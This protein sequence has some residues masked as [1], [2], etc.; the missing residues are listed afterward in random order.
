[1]NYGIFAFACLISEMWSTTIIH[2]RHEHW[3][4]QKSTLLRFIEVLEPVLMK[5]YTAEFFSSLN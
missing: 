4:F 1:M 2:L 3:A 5:R